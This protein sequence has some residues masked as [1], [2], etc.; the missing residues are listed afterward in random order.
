MDDWQIVKVVQAP[1]GE[2]KAEFRQSADGGLYRYHVSEW[3]PPEEDEAACFPDGFWSET[4]MSGL[5]ATLSECEAD[6]RRSVPWLRS[7]AP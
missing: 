1:E 7:P 3:F 4:D 2:R 5:Y 6:A